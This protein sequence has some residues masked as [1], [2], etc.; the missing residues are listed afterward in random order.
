MIVGGVTFPEQAQWVD[1]RH[2]EPHEGRVVLGEPAKQGAQAIQ[3]TLEAGRQVSQRGRIDGA[4]GRLLPQVI[5]RVHNQVSEALGGVRQ[6]TLE[7]HP[8][9][10]V[11]HL[12]EQRLGLWVACLAGRPER[13]EPIPELGQQGR[14]VVLLRLDPQLVQLVAQLGDHGLPVEAFLL[15]LAAPGHRV[16]LGGRQQGGVVDLDRLSP[17]GSQIVGCDVTVSRQFVS[18]AKVTSIC[19]TPRGRAGMSLRWNCPMRAD[20]S[21]SPLKTSAWIAVWLSLYVE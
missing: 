17:P 7:L 12:G 21:R 15:L 13:G 20:T 2:R 16:Q 1:G 14:A 19:G 6:L 4:G 5:L 10:R 11:E 9:D 3:L 18:I 8:A